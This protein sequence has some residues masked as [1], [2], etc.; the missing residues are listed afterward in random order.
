M[1]EK[2]KSK[3]KILIILA[4]IVAAIVSIIGYGVVKDLNQEK[5]LK[6][7]L[8]YLYKITN[9][10][11][12]NE[13]EIEKVLNRTI[14]KGDYKKVEI[15]YKKYTKD[16]FTIITDIM[17]VLDNEYLTEVLSAKNYQE[18]GK[19]FIKS[20]KFLQTSRETLQNSMIKYNDY[21][22]ET[23]AMSYLDKELDQYYI[24]FYK[25]ELVGNL[26][27]NDE[28]EEL[29]ASLNSIIDLINAEE[30]VIDFL[31]ENKNSWHLEEDSIAF[32]SDSL[33][34]EYEVLIAAVESES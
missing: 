34:A 14:S 9:Q 20:K 21:L 2:K 27:S 24:D 32:D 6:A 3:K 5:R 15:A 11:K 30:D 33:T 26:E 10:E 19:E 25:D 12:Y 7:E 17:S 29:F 18:D 22:T 28:D 13:S 8:D 23:K 31:V 16:C 1:K 4:I